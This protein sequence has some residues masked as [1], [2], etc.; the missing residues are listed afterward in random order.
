MAGIF[1][2]LGQ[3]GSPGEDTGGINKNALMLLMLGNMMQSASG[4]PVQGGMDMGA[5]A[6]MVAARKKE[7]KDEQE[8]LRKL[9]GAK[10]FAEKTG[11]QDLIDLIEVD[12]DSAISYIYDMRK[13]DAASKAAAEK[14]AADEKASRERFIWEKDQNKTADLEATRLAEEKAKAE[15]RGTYFQGDASTPRDMTQGPG[16]EIGKAPVPLMPGATGP[17]AQ[18]DVSPMVR[19]ARVSTG[20][21][22]LTKEEVAQLYNTPPAGVP[23]VIAALKE[24]RAASKAAADRKAIADVFTGGGAAPGA[25]VAA[26]GVSVPAATVPVA[27]QPSPSSVPPAS[28]GPQTPPEGAKNPALASIRASMG[29]PE[30][31]PDADVQRVANVF[32]IDP[33]IAASMVEDMRAAYKFKTDEEQAQA[34]LDQEKFLSTQ[35]KLE[36][37]YAWLDPTDPTKGSAPIKGSK[38]E[39]DIKDAEAA[40]VIADEASAKRKSTDAMATKNVLSSANVALNKMD[41]AIAEGRDISGTA[42]AKYITGPWIPESETGQL[43]EAISLIQNDATIQMILRMKERSAEMGGQGTGFGNLTEKEV[44]ILLNSVANLSIGQQPKELRRN[45]ASVKNMLLKAQGAT[46]GYEEG[47]DVERDTQPSKAEAAPSPIDD[48]MKKYPPKNR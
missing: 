46:E 3:G 32:A 22:D 19:S 44:D 30:G 8:R 35:P 23:N 1:D 18:P 31:V 13:T 24:S 42:V 47:T 48:I 29:I 39:R 10:R 5:V 40:K 21:L 9:E 36:P 15:T 43:K 34:K 2:M 7:Q 27:S 11:N 45:I 4:K 17:M 38:V 26:P 33:K 12:P 28:E 16:S 41:K 25:P 37:G 20:I 6:S 14:A